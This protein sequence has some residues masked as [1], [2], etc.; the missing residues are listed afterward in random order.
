MLV[1][2]ALIT[3]LLCRP[4]SIA[5]SMCPR[6]KLQ[7]LVRCMRGVLRFSAQ[8]PFAENEKVDSGQTLL[9]TG[10]S[11]TE[12]ARQLN[13]RLGKTHLKTQISST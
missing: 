3:H 10:D 1:Q 8:I 13:L 6:K 4:V 2:P 7:V 5:D 12:P 9:S 11:A